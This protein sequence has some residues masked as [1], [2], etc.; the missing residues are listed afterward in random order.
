MIANALIGGGIYL[1]K[2]CE[3][4][5]RMTNKKT[6]GSS[7][8]QVRD[9]LMGT[10]LKDIEIRLQRQEETLLREISNLRENLQSR[11]ESLENFMKN[12]SAS[13]LHRLQEEKTERVNL[14][15][16][17]QKDR[18]TAV[19]SEQQERNAAVK[20]EKKEREDAVKRLTD[21]L[22]AKEENLEAQI[23]SLSSTLDS[24]EQGLRQLMLSES[25]R[26]AKTMEEKYQE[27]MGAVRSTDAQIRH[28]VVSRSD[29]SGMFT[30]AAMR[31]SGNHGLASIPEP[32]EKKEADKPKK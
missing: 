21:E 16:R 2:D 11:V 26:L 5:D 14:L 13:L 31:F 30:E 22:A 23:E 1:N 24:A 10:H 28:D 3:K 15:K 18:Q 19:R 20:E 32:E 29:I 6:E 27:A 8:D 12:E 9:L 4:E 17:E 7:M 25:A